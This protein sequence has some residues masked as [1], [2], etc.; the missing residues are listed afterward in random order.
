LIKFGRLCCDERKCRVAIRHQHFAA[1][2]AIKIIITFANPNKNQRNQTFNSCIF[3]IM[4]IAAY[5][6]WQQVRALLMN[7]WQEVHFL[8]EASWRSGYAVDCKSMHP[9]SIPGEASIS[10]LSLFEVV[11]LFS[12]GPNSLLVIFL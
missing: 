9:G 5:Y 6:A 11:K 4:Q 2:I 8:H 12:K 10:I 1:C 7:R 3:N